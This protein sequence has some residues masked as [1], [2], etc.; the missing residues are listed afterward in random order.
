MDTERNLGQPTTATLAT[1]P[2]LRLQVAVVALATA[3]GAGFAATAVDADEV[4]Q[5][6]PPGTTVPNTGPTTTS[7]ADPTTPNVPVTP[8]GPT[9]TSMDDVLLAAS[10]IPSS[11]DI[12]AL[13]DEPPE[14]GCSPNAS[15][16]VDLAS[17]EYSAYGLDYPLNQLAVRLPS[18]AD[19]AAL[20]AVEYSDACPSST[21]DDG[22]GGTIDMT[23]TYTSAAERLLAGVAQCQDAV[24]SDSTLVLQPAA[25]TI[26]SRQ[27]GLLCGDVITT[28]T[29]VAN[30]R[31]ALGNSSYN[32]L[33][34]NIVSRA[35][36]VAG[37]SSGP[38]PTTTPT[39][40]TTTP[41]QPTPP[42]SPP[43]V[44]PP[45]PPPPPTTVAA[46]PAGPIESG[47]LTPADLPR[48]YPVMDTVDGLA[49]I[50]C[51]TLPT[52]PGMSRTFQF[53]DS[54]V[55]TGGG[56]LVARYGDPGNAMLA[57][58]LLTS[59]PDETIDLDG[60]ITADVVYVHT[61]VPEI[62]ANV[63][64]CTEASTS[65]QRV[66]YSNGNVVYV[67]SLTVLCGSTITE[68]ETIGAAPEATTAP[69]F[70]ALQAI[71]FQRTTLVAG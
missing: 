40:P 42:P 32:A 46:G 4:E 35:A 23:S 5:K 22:E 71:F 14:W 24:F 66:T 69:E 44:P 15:A 39:S 50:N 41:T 29:I 51:A 9:G 27:L 64:G 61:A 2:R 10:D 19:A 34:P 7:S 11:W 60:G 54:Q 8:Q 65:D 55:P 6:Q 57:Y 56:S 3:F 17:N 12:T 21:F 48:A 28:F 53:I 36:A 62:L 20:F 33:L 25:R 45:P 13:P 58:T 43:T 16:P 47:L 67:R 63:P 59:C 31:D 38:T 52:D 68:F 26:F 1:A 18:A 30:D 70:Q 49:L 37:P